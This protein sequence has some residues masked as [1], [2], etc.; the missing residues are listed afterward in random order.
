MANPSCEPDDLPASLP[1]LL[2]DSSAKTRDNP[3]SLDA[4]EEVRL[5]RLVRPERAKAIRIAAGVSQAAVARSLGVHP[6]TLIK[7]EHGERHPRGDRLRAYAEL[8]D[9]LERASGK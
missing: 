1:V 2:S 4:L 6:Q 8:L 5:R 3:E 7:W 9:R